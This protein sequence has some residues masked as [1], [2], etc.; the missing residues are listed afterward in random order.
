MRL[1]GG[2]FKALGWYKQDLYKV[3]FFQLSL[4]RPR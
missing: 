4:K 2:V 3:I 1:V